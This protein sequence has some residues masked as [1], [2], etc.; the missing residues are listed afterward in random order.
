MSDARE[1]PFRQHYPTL[2]PIATTATPRLK[3]LPEIKAVI[4][5]VYGTLVISGTG[6]VGSAD[7]GRHEKAL[8]EALIA[9]GLSATHDI[10]AATNRF[11]EIIAQQHEGLRA[12]G[13]QTPEVDIIEVWKTWLTDHGFD[14]SSPA[15]RSLSVEFE[16]RA[17]PA[18]EMPDARRVIRELQSRNFRL[19]FV[20]N[21]QF[22]TLD[23]LEISLQQ[24]PLEYGFDPD[25]AFFS[26]RYRIA[27][28]GHDL[29]AL[30]LKSLDRQGITA[31]EAIY[32]GNDMLNDVWAASKS[33]LKT[34]LFA[35]DKRSLRM[36]ENDERVHGCQPDIV[37]TSLEQ[38]LDV[39]R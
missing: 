26:Y 8:Q 38:L 15:A 2:E 34:A 7:T 18:C 39:C 33:G 17:N 11:R 20:S 24:L 14:A 35:G 37:L 4:F 25:L 19:G 13:I 1:H 30:L 10:S 9:C 32:V 23:L 12:K 22:F 27:K 16:C 21:A 28:P 31:D 29:F 6:D 3:R 36:R 5:D